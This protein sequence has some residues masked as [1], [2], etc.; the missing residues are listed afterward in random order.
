MTCANDCLTSGQLT[1]ATAGDFSA[2]LPWP[3]AG[4]AARAGLAESMAV[5]GGDAGVAVVTCADE[6]PGR[7]EMSGRAGF[8]GRESEN[9]PPRAIATWLSLA[10]LWYADK[11]FW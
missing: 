11:P 1:S 8:S 9:L 5:A 4:A 7:R 6:L 3:W 10:P 2:V